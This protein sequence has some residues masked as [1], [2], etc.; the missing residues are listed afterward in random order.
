MHPWQM[1]PW[2]DLAVRLGRRIRVRPDALGNVISSSEGSPG[3][4]KAG[5][6]DRGAKQF[7]QLVSHWRSFPHRSIYIGRRLG[8]NWP[9]G[10]I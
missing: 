1:R 7:C 9:R 6:K 3:A 2:R 4:E 5:H 8:F 10:Q